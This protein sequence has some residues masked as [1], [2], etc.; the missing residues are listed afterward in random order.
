MALERKLKHA[1]YTKTT[2]SESKSVA[3]FNHLINHDYVKSNTTTSDKTPNIDGY[4]TIT[5]KDQIVIGKL[6]VQIKTLKVKDST[7]PKY[8]CPEQFL[9]YCQTSQL[10]IL[11]ITADKKKQCAYW[12]YMDEN[13]INDAIK[14]LTGNSVSVK[15]P[16]ENCIDGKNEDYINSWIE[17]VEKR[18]E[19]QK[20]YPLISKRKEE[21][22]KDIELL[23]RHVNS[24][25]GKTSENFKE[26][27]IFLDFYNGLLDK[28]FNL[29]KQIMYPGYWKIGIGLNRYSFSELAY[30][31]FPVS[32]I[33][34][35]VLIKEIGKGDGFDLEKA[36]MEGKALIFSTNSSENPIK[37]RPEQYAYELIKRDALEVVKKIQVFV[38]D[39]F[40]G[41]EYL[42]SFVNKFY[43]LL[44]FDNPPRNFN[45]NDLLL[46]VKSIIYVVLEKK[47]GTIDYT[48]NID[49][50]IKY[51]N[52][53]EI[54]RIVSEAK[55]LLSKEYV[56]KIFNIYS[57]EF[58][59]SIVFDYINFFITKGIKI[60]E[61][62]YTNMIDNKKVEK[63]L[64]E[65]WNKESVLANLITY[66][67]NFPIIY[68]K[69]INKYFRFL[70]SDSKYFNQFDCLIILLN[71]KSP[72]KRKP[73]LEFFELK[74]DQNF[75]NKIFVYDEE[76]GDAPISIDKYGK[77]YYNRGDL[78]KKVHFSGKSFSIIRLGHR[79]IDFIFEN[80]PTLFSIQE[81]ISKD[82]KI[83]FN[84]KT[85][86]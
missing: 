29:V 40:L 34:N 37:T 14:R 52:K 47:Y 42:M 66:F 19:V 77:E 51:S 70:S 49:S 45:I 27:H 65:R 86:N 55:E 6:E 60:I 64:W 1:G 79:P 61:A 62:P 38:E 43:L 32:L 81:K 10:P 71:F 67:S 72:E 39:E 75:E 8:Q 82:L 46:A 3:L 5:E 17:I 59:L 73:Y 83:F 18:K 63:Y 22:E 2:P 35:D 44:G 21:L 31:L 80:T 68:E 9:A 25:V 54:S 24:A 13:V 33:E 84:E 4:V 58:N 7:S 85:K 30:I 28:E 23:K 74:C 26:I 48:F 57:E 12:L 76:N 15:I 50:F 20:Q 41:R 78:S 16:L 53:T 69:F 36:F 11:L 56:H